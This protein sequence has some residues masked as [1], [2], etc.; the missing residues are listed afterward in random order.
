MGEARGAAIGASG[1]GS[2]TGLGV[3]A[4]G[5]RVEVHLRVAEVEAFETKNAA[6]LGDEVSRLAQVRTEI[7]EIEEVKI[8]SLEADLGRVKEALAQEPPFTTA[9]VYEV[10][11]DRIAGIEAQI[12]DVKAE[13]VQMRVAKK[14]TD[15]HPDVVA[16]SEVLKGL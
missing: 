6:Y 14:W 7:Q 2:K 5:G 11:T 10:D 4:D 1:T 12:R 3:D 13:L 8:A 15:E 16:K 9:T